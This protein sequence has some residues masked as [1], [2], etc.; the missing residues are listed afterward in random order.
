MSNY[1]GKQPTNS[2][3][4]K[5]FFSGSE[6]IVPLVYTQYKSNPYIT[7]LDSSNSFYLPNNLV[8]IG[9]ITAGSVTTPSDIILKE[10]IE[11][12]TTEFSK[13]IVNLK[14][15]RYNYKSDANKTPYYGLIAQDLELY[16]PELVNL[17]NDG[18]ESTKS[19]NYIGIIPLLI[20]KIQDLQN[21]I[22]MLK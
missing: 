22:N 11:N 10:N 12:I 9:N 4:I 1:G 17:T 13:N 8:V 18:D 20:A 6:G 19:I 3:Y 21:Q 15:K 2:T 16:Y 5:Q 7:P 14:P